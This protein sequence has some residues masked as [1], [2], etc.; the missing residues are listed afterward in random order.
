MSKLNLSKYSDKRLY[1]LC[2][3]GAI[4]LPEL[5]DELAEREEKEEPAC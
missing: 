3:S 5:L 4:S 2:R 1:E